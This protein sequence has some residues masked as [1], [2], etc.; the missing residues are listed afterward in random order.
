MAHRYYGDFRSNDTTADPKGQRYRVLI[1][2][3]Y[4]GTH[5]YEYER[6]TH[7]QG[8]ATIYVGKVPIKNTAITMGDH[9]FTVSYQG[10]AENIYKPYRCSTASVSF[11]QST[12]NLDFL[13]AN[14]TSTMVLL[15]KWKNEVEE[16][17]GLH[18]KYMYNTATGETLQKNKVVE[19][20]MG[21]HPVE[22]YNDYNPDAYDAFCY[23]VEWVGFSTP[24][25]FSMDYS[26]TQDIFMLNAQDALSTLQFLKYK[27]S[28]TVNEIHTASDELLYILSQLSTYRRVRVTDTLKF[29]DAAGEDILTHISL[30]SMNNFD[31]DKKPQHQLEV[32]T[33]LL[34]YTGL[35]AIPWKDELLLTTPNAIAEGWAN[36]YTYELPTNGYILNWPNEGATYTYA[37]NQCL[38][39]TY[40]ITANSYAEGGTTISTTNIYNRVSATVDNYEVG[41]L[42]PDIDNTEDFVA[43]ASMTVNYYADTVT[44]GNEGV[45]NYYAWERK[46]VTPPANGKI[47]LKHYRPDY[48]EFEWGNEISTVPNLTSYS[49]PGC[50]ILEHGGMQQTPT[51]N[52]LP[53][54]SNYGRDFYFHTATY[55]ND[56]V[57]VSRADYQHNKNICWQP[58]L[59]FESDNVLMFSGDNLNLSGTWT[60]YEQKTGAVSLPPFTFYNKNAQSHAHTGQLSTMYNYVWGKVRVGDKWLCNSGASYAWSNTECKVKIYID[61]YD[62]KLAFSMPYEFLQT[63][64]NIKGTCIPLPIQ[65]DA[66]IFGNIRIELDRPLGTYYYACTSAE[67]KDFEVK[68]IT[69]DGTHNRNVEFTTE[70]DAENVTEYDVETAIGSQH[71]NGALWSEAVKSDGD[72]LQKMQKTY[73]TATANFHKP[74]QHITANLANQ[75]ATPTIT[76]NMTIHNNLTPYSLVKWPKLNGKRFIINSADLDYERNTN[77]VTITEVKTV[78][79][80]TTTQRD[81]T[82][83]YRRN[84]DLISNPLAT[85]DHKKELEGETLNMQTFGGFLVLNGELIGSTPNNSDILACTTIEANII[86][87]T[88]Q[89]SIPNDIDHLVPDVDEGVLWIDEV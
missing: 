66:C 16:R 26:H 13:N 49:N 68:I 35:T 39:N 34:K 77:N 23:T 83:N 20:E 51:A 79:P 57:S 46:M 8:G 70:I 1:F 36:Y 81:K 61:W 63:N 65:G 69:V 75:N 42:M 41:D 17:D 3:G 55:V 24:E 56:T 84:G 47:T 45:V 85:Y 15:L 40:T 52:T 62:G 82:R 25:T 88:M 9:P 31:E 60:F 76:L 73:N 32:L 78:E 18:A 4:D 71:T 74:E 54:N 72:T 53:L 27:R 87:G 37:G 12:I 21:P 38:S 50:Y 48:S 86:D 22:W 11:L 14:G 6:I 44:Q 5:P 28:S 2:A 64:R 89:L 58:M 43:D 29:S 10:D 80:H 33:R 7:P 30:Q 19:D 59:I 67:L